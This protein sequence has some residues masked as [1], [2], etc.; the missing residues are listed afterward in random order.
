MIGPIGHVAESRLGAIAEGTTPRETERR[1][2]AGCAACRDLLERHRLVLRMLAGPW[3]VR[4]VEAPDSAARPVDALRVPPTPVVATRPGGRP[5]RLVLPAVA[6]VGLALLAGVTLFVGVGPDPSRPAPSRPA[7]SRPA[8]PA[9]VADPSPTPR[10]LSTVRPGG[11]EVTGGMVVRVDAGTGEI[12]DTVDVPG[13]PG[14]VATA[15]G[16]VWVFTFVDGVV[17]RLDPEDGRA[18]TT[19]PFES[20]AAGIAADGEDLWVTADGSDLVLIDGRWGV[21]TSRFHLSDEPLFGPG[22]AGFVVVSGGSVWVTVPDLARPSEPHE[23]WRIDPETG[24]VE[25]KLTIDL[26]LNPPIAFQGAIYLVSP[27]RNSLTSVDTSLNTVTT[28][29]LGQEPFALAAGGGS[30]WVGHDR[31][32]QIRRIDPSTLETQATIEL[33]EPVR[34]LFSDRGRL[35]ATTWTSLHEI[36][37][38]REAVVRTTRL[39]ELP[40]RRGPAG[41]TVIDGAIWVGIEE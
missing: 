20:G 17:R 24:R 39:L 31:G 13:G 12:L 18:L 2:L 9:V 36:D 8:P 19:L 27:S 23:L 3:A 25:A 40:G 4:A 6:V 33:A 29:R 30:L 22:N 38:D 1:H 11:P 41:L 14:L 37:P 21:E 10:G 35:W 15:G 7:P 32:Q 34:A 16:Q 28:V 26:D 5:D